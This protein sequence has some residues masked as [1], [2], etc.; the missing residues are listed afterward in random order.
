MGGQAIHACATNLCAISLINGHVY[1]PGVRELREGR[2]RD[3]KGFGW[4]KIYVYV[5]QFEIVFFLFIFFIII[6]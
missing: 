1:V 4:L 5:I 3:R 2:E 6:I